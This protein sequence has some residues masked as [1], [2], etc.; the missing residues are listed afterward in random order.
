MPLL[1]SGGMPRAAD[2]PGPKC[3]VVEHRLGALANPQG[4]LF[5]VQLAAD[6]N[7]ALTA[8]M[9]PSGLQFHRMDASGAP[10]GGAVQVPG[11]WQELPTLLLSREEAVL[12]AVGRSEI[13]AAR[14]ER[15][16]SRPMGERKVPRPKGLDRIL[17]SALVD[18]EVL[19]V[20]V[21]NR[22]LLFFRIKGEGEPRSAVVHLEKS[23]PGDPAV[24][25]GRWDGNLAVLIST[26]GGDAWLASETRVE[27]ARPETAVPLEGPFARAVPIDLR[28]GA[29]TYGLQ[30]VLHHPLS[31]SEDADLSEQKP[32]EAFH[33]TGTYGFPA[34]GWTGARFL[35]AEAIGDKEEGHMDNLQVQVSAVSCGGK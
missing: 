25:L 18:G 14:F 15:R 35:F 20:A 9:G 7:G 19:L 11:S 16:S 24:T 33:L 13:T 26:I 4:N 21:L 10:A 27:S 32:P 12:V 23:L 22:D 2:V 31:R 5:P 30:I 8:W 28:T 17:V 3:Q 6:A 29:T 34:S 1:L